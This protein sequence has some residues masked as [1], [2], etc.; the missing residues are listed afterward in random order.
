MPVAEDG[1]TATRPK[2]V[3]QDALQNLHSA[4]IRRI[5][6]TLAWRSHNERFL[7]ISEDIERV[8]KCG[9][10]GLYRKLS[11]AD[12]VAFD[13]WLKANA[14]VASIFSVALVVMAFAGGR[15]AGPVEGAAGRNAPGLQREF[16]AHD[17]TLWNNVNRKVLETRER[18][19]RSSQ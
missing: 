17:P 13:R 2:A 10:P 19:K 4:G 14:V 18:H 8:E 7:S 6:S 12:R 16:P 9:M 1:L 3:R 5:L 15:P 11:C